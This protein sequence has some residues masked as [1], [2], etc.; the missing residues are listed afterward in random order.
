MSQS[1]TD[2]ER[3]LLTAALVETYE[4]VQLR[5]SLKEAVEAAETMVDTRVIAAVTGLPL[6]VVLAAGD[7][8]RSEGLIDQ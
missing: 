1:L 6:E 7:N 5:P 3:V 2:Q 8:L 4:Y